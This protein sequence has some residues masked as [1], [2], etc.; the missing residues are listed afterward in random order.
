MFSPSVENATRP[1][2]GLASERA[3]MKTSLILIAPFV[4]LTV[5]LTACGGSGGA[6]GGGSTGTGGAVDA[7]AQLAKF[8]DDLAAP[9][10]EALF[11]CCADPTRL[12][13][14]GGTL[15]GCK[16]DF[17]TTC[18]TEVQPMLEPH[19]AAGTTKLDEAALA[20]CV[21]TL[22]GMKAGG[23]AC[24]RPPTFVLQLDC[25]S[26]FKGTL[27]PGAACDTSTLNDTEWLICDHGACRSGKCQAFRASGA[28]CDP[29]EDDS[30]AAGCEFPAGEHCLAGGK[31]GP[32]GKVG[33]ACATP[34]QDKVFGCASMSCGP[35]GTCV[36]PTEYGICTEG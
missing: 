36:A 31:C 11:A 25:V 26:A 5:A 7:A 16:T 22:S 21:S 34:G 12:D 10:C 18:Q 23:A 9:Y 35:A 1:G 4:S 3:A 17:A 32:V 8:C 15:A 2:P 20:A 14:H 30:A 27:A 19:V 24:V 28:T 29:A 6:G 13:S 33:E